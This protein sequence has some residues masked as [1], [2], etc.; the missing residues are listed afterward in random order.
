MND[1]A[2]LDQPVAPPKPAQTLPTLLPSRAAPTR[3][4]DPT[5]SPIMGLY[6]FRSLDRTMNANL[7]R[8]T[9]GISPSVLILAYLDWLS[10]LSRAPGKQ[11]R[12]T[13]QGLRK[14]HRMGLYLCQ[15]AR[16][17]ET[18]P[19]IEPL[20]QDRRFRHPGW[21]QWPFNLVYQSFLLT[22]QWWDNATTGIRGVDA[23]NERISNFMT[24]QWLDLFSPANV[25]WLNPEII[26]ATLEQGGQNFARGLEN[27]VE[28]LERQAT[29]QKDAPIE[30][31]RVGKDVA[32]TPGKVVYRNRLMELI[33][34]SPSTETV[35]PEPILVV[36]AWIMKYYI[37]DLSPHN[38]MVRY[39]VNQG[40]T[41][42]M[43]SW[44][45]P[46]ADD[47]DIGLDDY[48]RQ[49]V[50]EALDIIGA[51]CPQR[52]I[53]AA[54]YCIGGTLLSIAAATMAR[55]GDQRL[56]SMTLFAAQAD[57][58]EP[59]E[60]SLFINESQVTYLEDMMWDQ[61]YLESH[62]MA[63]AFQLLR[64]QDLIWSRII[65]NYLLGERETLNDLMAWNADT[66]RMPYQMHS[67]YLRKLFL[68]NDLAEGRYLVDDRPIALVDIK[69]PLFA[70]GTLQDH[71]APWRSAYKTHSLTRSE[72]TVF[73]LTS[74]GHNAGIVSEPG[75][76]RRHYQMAQSGPDSPYVD[77]DSWQA[78]APRHEGSWWPAWQG[79]L[80]GL[81]GERGAP[82]T[83]GAP[84]RGYPPMEDAPGRY[85]LQP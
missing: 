59:G 57:F 81:S 76:P 16:D 73:L 40:H 6:A 29:G 44:L 11:A 22:Q 55:D 9:G 13:E 21:Q 24:R 14:L 20:P 5:G 17:P 63:G 51:I 71:V 10:H 47:C 68:N 8:F 56:A 32:V 75:H 35:Y 30:G 84:T 12:L 36:P 41:V 26:Q 83:M 27:W 38:S 23:Q 53:H 1:A 25:P 49:G 28:D 43:I 19:C 34:Y 69:V 60:L 78:A 66:T 3:R 79:W 58:T 37:L 62:R 80:A 82:P 48:R 33:Q 39:L 54:G 64:S 70:V 18:A 45:N 4:Q 7:A 67:E 46:S 50:M 15:L 61:G 31:F 72:Q 77:P 74:G 2:V 52:R 65:H 85:V 42:F